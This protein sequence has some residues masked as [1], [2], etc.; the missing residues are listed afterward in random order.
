[1]NNNNNKQQD[2]RKKNLA[3]KSVLLTVSI[4]PHLHLQLYL[5]Y[6]TQ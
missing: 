6:E 3:E 2:E 1:M 4:C 5:Y